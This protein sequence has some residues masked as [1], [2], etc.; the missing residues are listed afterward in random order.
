MPRS[1]S[2]LA[3]YHDDGLSSP[4]PLADSFEDGAT[5]KR[6]SRPVRTSSPSKNS[7]ATRR[8]SRRATGATAST[9]LFH[10]VSE[11]NLSPWKIKVTVEAEPEDPEMEGIAPRTMTRTMKIPLRHDSSPTNLE[12]RFSRERN[13][14]TAP[15]KSK[16]SGTPV[17]GA[18]NTSRSR[19]QSVTDLNVRPLGDDAE[20]DDWLRQKKSPRKQGTSRSRKADEGDSTSSPVKPGRKSAQ[21]AVEV[22][23]DTDAEDGYDGIHQQGSTPESE[24]PELRTIDLNRVSVRGR[25]VSAKSTTDSMPDG[26]EKDPDTQQSLAKPSRQKGKEVRKVSSNSALSYP[27][28]SPS[29]SFH[30]DPDDVE[31][32]LQQDTEGRMTGE[33]FDTVL[34][35][36]GFTMIDLDTLPS[37]RQFRSSPAMAAESH[38]AGQERE[39]KPSDNPDKTHALAP[40]GDVSY[41]ALNADESEISSTVPSS[42]PVIEQDRSLLKVPAPSS[43]GIRRV[44]PQPYSSPKLPSPPRH[45]LQRTANHRHRGSASALFAGIALQEVVSPEHSERHHSSQ[46][47]QSSVSRPLSSHEDHLFEGFD[48]RTKRELRA[49]LRFGEEL[50]KRQSSDPADRAT[51]GEAPARK[52]DVAGLGI[53]SRHE[54]P[55]PQ[56]ATQVRRGETVVQHTPV[57]T[58]SSMGADSRKGGGN[59]TQ[60][61]ENQSIMRQKPELLDTMA[62][63]EREWQLEREAVSRQIENASESQVIIIDSDDESALP[64]KEQSMA[65][66]SQC[67]QLHEDDEEDIWLAEAKNSSSSP[68]PATISDL[69]VQNE[70][71]KQLHPPKEVN[72][73]P[74]RGLIPRPWRR[75]DDIAPSV[76]QSTFL[77]T[78]SDEMSGLGYWKEQESKIKFGAGEIRR[79]QLGQRRSSGTFDIDLMLGTPKKEEDPNRS[80]DTNDGYHH[81]QSDEPAVSE[82]MN[83]ASNSTAES[84]DAPVDALDQSI[85]SQEETQDTSAID[86]TSVALTTP[87]VPHQDSPDPAPSQ[88]P[89]TPRSALK[90]SRY[91]VGQMTG[92]AKADTPTMIR[93]VVFSERSRGVDIDGMESSFSMKTGSDDTTLGEAGLQLRRELE[94]HEDEHEAGLEPDLDHDVEDAAAEESVHTVNS[95]ASSEPT[96]TPKPQSRQKE[97]RPPKRSTEPA[98]EVNIQRTLS[99]PSPI[100]NLDGTLSPKQQSR[101]EPNWEKAKLAMSSIDRRSNSTHRG[102]KTKSRLPSYLLPPSYPSDPSRPSSSRLGLS[103]E[104]TNS[105]FRTLH[106]IYRKSLRPKFHGPGREAIRPDVLALEGREMDIDET[107]S[108]MGEMFT[109]TIGPTECAVIERFM[110]EVEYSNGFYRGKTVRQDEDVAGG[111]EDGGLRWGWTADQIGEWLCRIVVGEVVREEE[112]RT[113]G[114]RR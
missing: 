62:R 84:V 65:E 66:H 43:V 41:P 2:F 100:S 71:H 31:D 20:E 39:N 89:P 3:S 63:R 79:H 58:S 56:Q 113:R 18:R 109:W 32:T 46:Q 111:R 17:R 37:A 104:F 95:S 19:R 28:P 77:S 54:Q 69:P 96:P 72:D 5:G 55:K 38:P 68:L 81:E 30:G 59:V 49:G 107:G 29:S 22:R 101:E 11:Q 1:P 53:S 67:D 80:F 97:E 76:E 94:A 8:R 33:G 103:G 110:Q 4:D 50:A 35:S 114:G 12:A 64:V 70:Q 78:N 52:G 99:S 90:G 6:V 93:R 106:I 92:F 75:G 40:A 23:Q 74:R 44:T 61:P 91:S 14:A 57:H 51:P 16:R 85:S 15:G 26:D 105:H 48:S 73:K 24:S 83:D 42:P 47:K 13:S 82:D 45:I 27:T 7:A 86:D 87:P 102:S 98:A 108:G 36:E 25:P 21:A 34:E 9:P 10:S 112:K 88:R 60:T